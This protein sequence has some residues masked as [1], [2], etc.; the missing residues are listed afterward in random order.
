MLKVGG[1][2]V[3]PVEIE[4]VLSEHEAV[5]EC[6]VI[7]QR[8]QAELIKPKAY[9]CLNEGYPTSEDTLVA[10]LKQCAASLDVHKRPRWI[11]FIDG[12]PRTATGKVQ[13][14]KLY[15]H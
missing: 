14:F 12:L 8:D 11:E 1:L 7:G 6:A 2:W 4:N 3:S 13:R 9:V 10:L 5:F 15:D